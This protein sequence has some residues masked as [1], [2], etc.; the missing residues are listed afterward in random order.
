[1]S[2]CARRA[3]H[4]R[5]KYEFMFYHVENSASAGTAVWS[6]ASSGQ[7]SHGVYVAD[8]SVIV[9]FDKVDKLALVPEL[10]GGAVVISDLVYDETQHMASSVASNPSFLSST[11]HVTF[12]ASEM[13]ST[14]SSLSIESMD[15]VDA[16]VIGLASWIPGAIVLSI[17]R[18]VREIAAD[19]SIGVIGSEGL[20]K[21]GYQLGVFS[22]EA[23]SEIRRDMIS[24]GER[25]FHFPDDNAFK[26]YL[27]TQ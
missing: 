9:G 14:Y 5:Q 3:Q 24:L 15:K 17:D 4:G 2:R 18:E 27:V 13:A 1:M 20:L 8:T 19:N 26:K 12:S 7:F 16:S 22:I 6:M 23:A 25:L 21:R 10:C 11:H